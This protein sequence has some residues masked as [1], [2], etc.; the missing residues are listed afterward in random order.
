MVCPPESLAQTISPQ[1]VRVK[2]VKPRLEMALRLGLKLIYS[3][4]HGLL[5]PILADSQE[6]VDGLY[7]TLPPAF[8]TTDF[9]LAEQAS[10]SITNL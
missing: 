7:D 9:A 4:I 10:N 1:L 3:L 8:S 2:I 5:Q 6:L